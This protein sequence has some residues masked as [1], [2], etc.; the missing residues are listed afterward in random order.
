M[1]HPRSLTAL[2]LFTAVALIG[3]TLRPLLPIDE[4][5]YV[6]VAWDMHVT[7]DY[8]VPTKNFEL[9]THKPPVLFW[10]IN[11]LWGVFGVSEYVARLAAPVFTVTALWLT[12]R[13]ATQLWP[14]DTGIGGRAVWALAGTFAFAFYGGATMFDTALATATL[15]GLLS[16]VAAVRTGLWRY[17]AGLGVALA[18]GVLA[19]GPVIFVHLLPAVLLVPFWARTLP[20]VRLPRLGAGLGI[21]I[22]TGVAVAGLWLGPAIITGGAEY[23]D[24]V[25]W[26]Q[27]AGRIAQSFAHARPVYWYAT[28][29]PVFLFPWI[30]IPQLWRALAKAQWT[31]TGLRLAIAWAGSA[32]VLF[33]LISGKQLHY[34]IPEL[35]AVALVVARLRP[36][37]GETRLW[38]PAGFIAALGVVFCLAGLGVVDATQATGLLTPRVTLLAVGL[39]LL[40]I[41]GLAL[42]YPVLRGGAILSLGLLLSLGATVRFTGIYAAYDTRS[43]GEYIAPF[44]DSGIA[45]FTSSYHAEFNFAARATRHMDQIDTPQGLAQWQIDHPNGVIVGRVDKTPITATPT[46][47]VVFRDRP[48]GLWAVADLTQK[49]PK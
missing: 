11:L 39:S 48:Y 27:S 4:T 33:S 35:P 25:L 36:T 9:Y 20:A 14:E 17:W 19:K 3:I 49:D 5:R 10:L 2:V 16:L 30:F 31:D 44:E 40:A 37:F 29:L 21:A 26:K 23:R 24:A 12:G 43:I 46:D 38:I 7:G 32:F 6:G 18:V 47:T 42:N 41:C 28:V 45:V 8:F 34:L 15:L 13:L 22:L 1:A